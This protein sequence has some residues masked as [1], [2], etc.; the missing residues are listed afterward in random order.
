MPLVP[1]HVLNN[2]QLFGNTSRFGNDGGWI[3]GMMQLGNDSG[4][5][6]SIGL[7]GHMVTIVKNTRTV[8]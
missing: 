4:P 3:M 1:D 7:K 6:K 8:G 2:N 5:I